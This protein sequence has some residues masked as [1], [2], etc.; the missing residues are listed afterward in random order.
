MCIPKR[1]LDVMQLWSWGSEKGWALLKLKRWLCQLTVHFRVNCRVNAECLAGVAE[2]ECVSFT[3]V[4]VAVQR[5]KSLRS[6]SESRNWKERK[7]GSFSK[8]CFKKR[9]FYLV[10][11]S[12]STWANLFGAGIPYG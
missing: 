6:G 12:G 1:L 2:G 3:S 4:T 10:S 7:L 8:N 5:F 9:F 11:R